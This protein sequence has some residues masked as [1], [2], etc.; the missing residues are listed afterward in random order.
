MIIVEI[1]I[2]TEVLQEAKKAAKSLGV[3]RG[4]ITH[5]KGNVIGFI[6]EILAS[7]YIGAIM[8]R[9]YDYDMVYKGYTIDVKTKRT[10]IEHVYTNFEA[11]ISNWN[12]HQKCDFYLFSRV[13]LDKKLCWLIGYIKPED[14]FKHAKFMKKGMLDKSNGYLIKYDCWNLPYFH[15]KSIKSL[16]RIKEKV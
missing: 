13:N 11:S 3:L 9:T 8:D 2:P 6:G 4:S 5:G 7:E 14:Y 15:L 1:V 10:T 16:Q 12:P